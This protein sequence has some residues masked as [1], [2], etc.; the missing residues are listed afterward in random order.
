MDLET[1]AKLA[2]V[3]RST[4]SRVINNHPHVSPATRE[5]VLEIIRKKNFQPNL[6]ARGLAK[7]HTRVL[8][9][10]I[11]MSVPALF[12][13]PYFSTFIQGVAAACNVHDHSVMLWLA[14]PEYERRTIRQILYSGLIDG[15]IVAS[16]LLDDPVVQA[17]VESDFPFM[18]NGRHPG[19]DRVNYVDIDNIASAREAVSHL[20][21]LGRR[22]IGTVTGPHNMIAG[23]DRLLGYTLALR[24]RGQ[25]VDAEL[26][27]ES[28][29]TET[30]GYYAMQR[31]MA[32]QPDAVFVASD[33]MAVGVLQ[34]LREA[35]RRVPEDIA[36]VGFDDMPFAAR[37][38]PP[39]TT[40]RQP[41][42]R[43]GELATETLI[44]MIQHPHAAPR[45]IILPTELVVRASCGAAQNQ[46]GGDPANIQNAYATV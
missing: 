28:D 33:T 32:H 19:N 34:A 36:V 45:R 15:V 25:A 6:A 38:L 43:S 24:D 22:R 30:G 18:M 16:N 26:V 9:L 7:G 41:I 1:I 11:P 29:F 42:Q 14:D 8:G 12:T 3:S 5:R 40:I 27:V 31:L 2:K 46:K 35:G 44:D 10:V 37:T 21:R 20:F 13:D 4:V 39:L 17:L 23:A